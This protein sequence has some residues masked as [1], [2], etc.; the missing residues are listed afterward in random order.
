MS[1]Y[2]VQG[3]T[4]L[5]NLI[6]SLSMLFTDEEANHSEAKRKLVSETLTKA[7]TCPAISGVSAPWLPLKPNG[8]PQAPT[9]PQ[10]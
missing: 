3:L 8:T 9:S 1:T 2:Y 4:E 7:L 10:K 6:L 5:T